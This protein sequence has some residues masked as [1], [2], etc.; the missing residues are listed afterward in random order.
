VGKVRGDCFLDAVRQGAVGTQSH[1]EGGGQHHHDPGTRRASPS[2]PAVPVGSGDEHG[3][4]QAREYD[5]DHLR[6]SLMGR[7][8]AASHRSAE[9]EG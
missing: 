5:V 2:A 3:H 1:G 7:V 9:P 4:G 6:R 8:K